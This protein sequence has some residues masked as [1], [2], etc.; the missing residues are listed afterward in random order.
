ME[1]LELSLYCITPV[2]QPESRGYMFVPSKESSLQGIVFTRL[3]SDIRRG[4]PDT[5]HSI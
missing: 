2:H 5:A 3:L 1:V 4:V